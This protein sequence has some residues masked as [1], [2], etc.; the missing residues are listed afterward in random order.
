MTREVPEWVGKTDD[1][2][3]PPRVRLRV[4][5]RFGGI[6]YL[7]HRKIMPGE[8]WELEHI[9]AIINGGQNRESNMAP[10]LVAPHKIKSAEDMAQKSKNYRVRAKHL[11]IAPKR[12]KINSPGFRK[13]SPQRTASRPLN[14]GFQS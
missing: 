10:A 9:L 6:C 3:A 14:R 13:A 1:T 7:S 12:A 8:A 5:E 11:G 2:P 4:F